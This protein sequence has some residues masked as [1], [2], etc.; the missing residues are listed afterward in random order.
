MLRGWGVRES[1]NLYYVL[2]D[3]RENEFDDKICC[4]TNRWVTSVITI[5][6]EKTN[7]DISNTVIT[8]QALHNFCKD[9][10]CYY[11]YPFLR[12]KNC[13]HFPL[14]LKK[15]NQPNHARKTGKGYF[16]FQCSR[17]KCQDVKL[18]PGAKR[19]HGR[20]RGRDWRWMGKQKE[21]SGFTR[22]WWGCKEVGVSVGDKDGWQLQDK[23][24]DRAV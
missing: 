6:F 18:V 17:P 2:A 24:E 1:D 16:Y 20:A 15:K 8:W 3:C 22:R 5:N 10:Y 21:I 23:G 12:C 14:Y 4:L 9:Q 19:W 7:R 11:H 13:L